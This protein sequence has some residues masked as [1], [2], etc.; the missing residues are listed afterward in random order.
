[1]DD[2]FRSGKSAGREKERE[3]G[4]E[5]QGSLKDTGAAGASLLLL[6]PL[7]LPLSVSSLNH[8]SYFCL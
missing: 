1:M 6:A 2:I 7:G 5:K 4:A 8:T 3:R